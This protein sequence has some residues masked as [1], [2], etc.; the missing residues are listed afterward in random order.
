MKIA[1]IGRSEILFNAAR[2]VLEKGHVIPLVVTS[3][4]APEYIYDE[5]SFEQ[6]ATECGARFIR[7]SNLNNRIGELTAMDEI[8]IAI[9]ANYTGILSE[10]IV[11]LFRLGILN[12]HGGDLPLYRGNACQA[13]AILNGE[14]RVGL[15]V[16]K[17]IGGQLDNG[18]IIA[19]DYKMISA[20]TKVGTILDWI[21]KRSPSLFL[22]SISSLE[23]NPAYILEKQS[24]DRNDVL[25][26]YPRNPDDGAIT[27][28]S[29]A[30][31]ILRLIN[32]SNKP[33]AGAF[34][35]FRGERLIVWDAEL[36][37]DGERFL[38]IPG[39]VTEIAC[40]GVVVSTG[41][42]KLKLKVVEYRSKLCSPSEF[43]GSMRARFSDGL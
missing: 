32:A 8:D 20:N 23:V 4:A 21:A 19:R 2:M 39:Q 10:E 1:V 38:A 31:D 16:H 11:G 27:W 28:S 25:R 41:Q 9:S 35:S 17:M 7:A 36:C 5:T 33:Y 43:V 30:I 13:W 40:D 14:R 18:D 15:C 12:A 37:D 3:K 29:A 42:G 22:E 6:L 24:T 26:C 34:C